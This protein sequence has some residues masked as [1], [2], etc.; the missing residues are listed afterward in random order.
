[1]P[2]AQTVPIMLA[3]PTVSAAPTLPT[4]QACCAKFDRL[5]IARAMH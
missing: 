4:V 3:V 2:I 1:V 5:Q